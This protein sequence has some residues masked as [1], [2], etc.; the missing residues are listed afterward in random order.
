MGDLKVSKAK[1]KGMQRHSRNRLHTF[2][3]TGVIPYFQDQVRVDTGRMRETIRA[4][5]PDYDDA[6][7]LVETTV[8]FG[9]IAVDGVVKEQGTSRV[10][11]YVEELY[12][13]DP[14]DGEL[15]RSADNLSNEIGYYFPI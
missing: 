2:V 1:L 14:A 4:D 12:T 15:E 9:G 11:D 13:T 8:F 3:Q 7:K 10:V 5:Y 6:T